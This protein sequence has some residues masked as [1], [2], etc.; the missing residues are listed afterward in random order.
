MS[1][2]Q[3]SIPA[4]DS[5]ADAPALS[6]GRAPRF[7]VTQLG[8]RMHYAVPR[9]LSRAGVL[10]HF[11]TDICAVKGWP[12]HLECLPDGLRTKSIRR[13]LG[14]VPHGVPRDQITGF[15]GLGCGYAW[16]QAVTR[17]AAATTKVHLWAARKF[18]EQVSRCDWGSATGVY[19]FNSA[20]LETLR[21]ARQRGVRGFLEQTIAPWELRAELLRQ[22]EESFPNWTRKTSAPSH[23]DE[24]TARQ[25]AEWEHADRILCGSEFVREGIAK[26]GGPS[27]RCQVV[28]YGVEVPPR[29][30]E[31]PSPQRRPLRVLT[32]GCVGLRKGSPYVMG[33]AKK[34][35]GAVEF[36][37]VG[38]VAL[39]PKAKAELRHWIEL[40]GPV[41]RSEVAEHFRWADV[42]LLPSLCEGSATVVYEALGA[43]L[44]V[45]CTH[46]AGSVVRDRIDGYLVPIRDID[47]IVS[48][49]DR[50]AGHAELWRA[51]SA[52]AR[53]RAEQF[54]LQQYAARLLRAII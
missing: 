27:D 42:F 13:L 44:P 7:L 11:Y 41:P 33:A 51:M 54:T 40:V 26:C 32:V 5:T 30:E 15:T 50:L 3:K 45:I 16:R 52:H 4:I 47:T 38:T 53:L 24:I 46:N 9:I 18:C 25:H 49:L 35:R 37:M 21:T 17:S 20:G 1:T 19:A 6:S 2:I 28:P 48:R 34:L 8:A 43:G 22:E 39:R 14:R 23:A 12:R 36:R 10:E 29:R 31:K